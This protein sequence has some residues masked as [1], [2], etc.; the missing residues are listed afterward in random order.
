MQEP[1]QRDRHPGIAAGSKRLDPKKT[2]WAISNAKNQG[3]L[4]DQLEAT[5]GG[6]GKLTAD[7]YRRYRKALAAN[8]ALDFDDLLPSL[9]VLKTSRCAAIGTVVSVTFWW[10]SIWTPTAPT[11]SD[12]ATGHQWQGFAISRLVGRSVFVV[13][14]PTRVSAAS[15]A[16][17]T[18]LMV[19]Q[20]DLAIRLLMS[21]RHDGG[22]R[23]FAHCHDPGGGQ[24][25]DF[26]QQRTDRQSV[27]PHAW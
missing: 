8:N 19:F 21:P 4:P 18:I 6:A 2:R 20:D 16:D 12:Q 27:A 14:T 9:C 7:V 26:Q 25:A 11:Q 3:W 15:A 23:E 5:G 17:F 24:C 22:G 10:M 1:G 13:V